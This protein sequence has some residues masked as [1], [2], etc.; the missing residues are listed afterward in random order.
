[1]CKP[2]R[3]NRRAPLDAFHRLLGL[4][5]LAGVAALAQRLGPGRR[6]QEPAH[7]P[8]LVRDGGHRCFVQVR[9]GESQVFYVHFFVSFLISSTDG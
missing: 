9:Y 2:S 4:L 1:M 6:F 5:A 3:H 7:R 8:G